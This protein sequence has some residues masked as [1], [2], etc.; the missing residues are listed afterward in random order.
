MQQCL[1][2]STKGEKEGEREIHKSAGTRE[3]KDNPIFVY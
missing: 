3:R 1:E 2:T